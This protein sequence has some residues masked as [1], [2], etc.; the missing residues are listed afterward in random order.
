MESIC[1]V[2]SGFSRSLTADLAFPPS[3]FRENSTFLTDQDKEP[4]FIEFY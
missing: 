1:G 4:Q 3:C 2:I